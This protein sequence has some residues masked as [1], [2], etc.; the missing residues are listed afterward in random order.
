MSEQSDEEVVLRKYL[1][2]DLDEVQRERIEARLFHDEGFAEELARAED[3]LVDDYAFNALPEGDREKFER[4]F[5]LTDERRK[6]LLLAQ[7]WDAYLEPVTGEPLAPVTHAERGLPWWKK[8]LLLIKARRVLV[9][10]TAAAVVLLII[11]TPLIVQQAQRARI[12][13]LLAEFN[14]RPLSQQT[15]N[16][17]A[18]EMSLRPNLLRG[19]DGLDQVEIGPDVRVL[20]LRLALP[21]VQYSQ[22]TV[23]V[24]TVGGSPLFAVGNLSSEMNGGPAALLLRIPSELMPTNDYQL[25]LDGI[26]A[27][28]SSNTIA[29]YNLRVINRTTR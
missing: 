15:L 20:N 27:D 10:A 26:G 29:L 11:V 23:R 22:Y 3:S 14:R 7:A 2:A 13:R 8:F 17:P 1:L 24:R 5:I 9:T 25:D 12:Q 18:A 6:N 4:N 16:L 21:S 19:G 28:G